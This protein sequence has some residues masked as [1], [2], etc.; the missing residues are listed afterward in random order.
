VFAGGA[1]SGR[2]GIKAVFVDGVPYAEAMKK[3][4]P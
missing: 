1:R 3:A 4:G 2:A